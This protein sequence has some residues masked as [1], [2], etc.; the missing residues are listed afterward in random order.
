MRALYVIT[1]IVESYA[2][3]ALYVRIGLIVDTVCIQQFII[4][5][6]RMRIAIMVADKEIMMENKMVVHR[7]R[8]VV[9]TTVGRKKAE[10]ETKVEGRKKV[11][12]IVAVAGDKPNFRPTN[13]RVGR[14]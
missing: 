5:V 11:E 13:S 3:I 2:R 9:G 7:K 10:V 14:Q 1:T 8:M 4:S 12:E 6:I